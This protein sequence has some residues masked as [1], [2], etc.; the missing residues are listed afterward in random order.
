M[1][2][3]E[4][5]EQFTVALTT[6]APHEQ[7]PKFYDLLI[8]DDPRLDEI[9]VAGEQRQ[10]PLRQLLA[11]SMIESLLYGLAVGLAAHGKRTSSAGKAKEVREVGNRP[12]GELALDFH[13]VF[14]GIAP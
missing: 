7:T 2:L 14:A 13:G 3:T 10:G 6:P 9:I 4:T 12:P 8:R 11:M 5:L 1:A